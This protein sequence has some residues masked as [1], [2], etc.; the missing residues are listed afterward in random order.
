MCVCYLLVKMDMEQS[1]ALEQM[2]AEPPEVLFQLKSQLF[3]SFYSNN[4]TWT[5][6]VF[7]MKMRE[8]FIH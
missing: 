6:K 5:K 3:K 2:D 7:V 8:S 4:I 1:D